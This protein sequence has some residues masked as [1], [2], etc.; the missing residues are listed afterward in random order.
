MK[1]MHLCTN[2]L[3]KMAEEKGIIISYRTGWIPEY[4]IS[5]TIKVKKRIYRKG[6]EIDKKD[7]YE[8]PLGE[9]VVK[10]FI[11]IQYKDIDIKNPMISEEISRYNRKF[12]PEKWF[13][14]ITLLKEPLNKRGK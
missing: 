8:I 4:T 1:S 11:P 12:H 9:W 5:E 2:K 3:I 10:K 13:F 14:E 7:F 6:W